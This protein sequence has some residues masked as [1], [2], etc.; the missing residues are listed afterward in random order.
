LKISWV[1]TS[2]FGALS[3]GHFA[4]VQRLHDLS[5]ND[6]FEPFALCVGGAEIG[7][8]IIAAINELDLVF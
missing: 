5:R 4:L 1:A 3:H 6:G 8:N 2:Q 7:K